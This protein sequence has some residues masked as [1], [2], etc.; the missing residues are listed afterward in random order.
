MPKFMT[1]L[2]LIALGLAISAISR[3][4][5]EDPTEPETLEELRQAIEDV[6]E[7]QDVPAIGIAIV[8][9]DGPAWIEA[10]GKADLAA[11]RDA[12]TDSMFRIGSTSKMFV[13]LSVLKL[14]E[15]G[16]L[17]LD[18][19][20]A[21]LAP[22]IEWDN[23][24]AATDPIRIV[25]L[26]EHTTGWDDIHLVEYAR[27]DPTPLTLKEALDHHPHSRRSRWKPGT[28]SSYC[29]S[30]P[31][32]AAYVVQ[33][34]TG[35]DFEDYARE[36]FFEPMGMETISYRRSPDVEQHGVTLYDGGE[37]QNYW[38][39][40]M[41]PSGSIN[42]SPK[43]MARF[44]R[45]FV[46]RGRVD[47]NALVSEASLARMETVGSTPAAAAGQTIGYALHNYSSV[48]EQW[49][50]RSHNG[51]VNGGLSDLSYLPGAGRGYHFA[52]NSGNGKAFSEITRLV[53]SY[54]TR[55][56][57]P[58]QAPATVAL[59][60]EHTALTGI[61]RAINP[62]QELTR[63]L[64]YTLNM[65]RLY[66]DDGKLAREALLGG[67]PRYFLPVSGQLFIDEESGQVSMSAVDD[68][69]A[70]PVIHAN[71]RVFEKVS[72]LTAYGTLAVGA[73]WML[74]IVIS[75]PYLLVWGVRRLR[76]RI[77]SGATI[78]VRSWP[79]LAG[80][81][82]LT[83]VGLYIGVFSGALGDPFAL[84]GKPTPVSISMFLATVAFAFFA[85][86]GLAEAWWARATPM[87]RVNYWYSA[88]S[89]GLH[90]LVALYLLNFGIIGMMPWA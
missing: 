17:S 5:D 36:Q 32:V 23:P 15:E 11:D 7:E 43:D 20:L 6:L 49:V 22:E 27:N 74:S 48:Y 21:D 65:S 86:L 54:L 41:R 87:N 52:I 80:L 29:N 30:G 47:G 84:L 12:T 53:R 83:F 78:R 62:R 31:P 4:A 79:L 75:L 90:T 56:L 89:S 44:V 39:I 37:P 64:D 63:F 81:S 25:H 72:P 51:G 76:G 9:G 33:K 45:F 57:E 59:G 68:P 88:V 85:A 34:I 70:G 13:A 16:R 3:G 69:L 61:Y 42:A 50:F 67:E 73:L 60:P 40:S 24:W 77:P 46:N 71:T 66:I 28:R 1:A 58:P 14:V 38:H 8:E 18:D 10:M 35:Q 19:T 55:D 2:L 26:L 82:I